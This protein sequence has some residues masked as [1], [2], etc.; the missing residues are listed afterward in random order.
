MGP[1]R[2][3]IAR[4]REMRPMNGNARNRSFN[5]PFSNL[6]SHGFCAFPLFFLSRIEFRVNKIQC[7]TSMFLVLPHASQLELLNLI[8][9]YDGKLNR[10]T[11][12]IFLVAKWD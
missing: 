6:P 5:R 8:K 1:H 9:L 12:T 4:V 7:K 10:I 3:R 2:Q 11:I